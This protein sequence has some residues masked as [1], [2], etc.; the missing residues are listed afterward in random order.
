MKKIPLSKLRFTLGSL[1]SL[2]DNS[3]EGED[4]STSSLSSL[5]L[6][7]ALLVGTVVGGVA[8]LVAQR[9][10]DTNPTPEEEEEI[11][12]AEDVL[13]NL[14]KP[15][16]D[17]SGT[18]APKPKKHKETSFMAKLSNAANRFRSFVGLEPKVPQVES[19]GPT[20]SI[21]EQSPVTG[22]IPLT[23]LKPG[24]RG[25]FR[26][27]NNISGGER[28]SSDGAYTAE[29]AQQIVALKQAKTNT[30]VTGTMPVD[31]HDYI[32]QRAPA[33]GLDP[34]QVLKYAAMESGGNPNAISPTGAIGVFQFTGGTASDYGV[35]N[36]FDMYENIEAGLK[37]A[38]NNRQRLQAKKLP[39]TELS[40]YIAHQIGAGGA[41]EVLSVGATTPIAAL[42]STT[43][44]NISRNV[45]G[46]SRTVGE[47]LSANSKA[48]SSS[49]QTRVA[50]VYSNP[51][52]AASTTVAVAPKSPTAVTT[53][54]PTNTAQATT[55][56]AKV[57]VAAAPVTPPKQE[58]LNPPPAAPTKVAAASP[59]PKPVSAAPAQKVAAAVPQDVVKV[60]KVTVST[61]PPKA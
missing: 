1:P 10:F 16:G 50:S 39:V 36:R 17:A 51:G 9:F 29:E 37:L 14:N 46:N 20:V 60:G 40:L 12:G 15:E 33:Y 57:Q 58:R 2:V 59:T 18:P 52:V 8:I 21:P 11:P 22:L 27:P 44:L 6:V 35:K 38:A 55:P 43:R 56:A 26:F 7:A 49:Y 4:N 34:I 47:Y 31:V 25:K 19:E 54:A 32:V 41:R 61:T 13:P 42:S 45:G 48:L 3:N 30:G 24:Y 5:K 23:P 53:P 28:L